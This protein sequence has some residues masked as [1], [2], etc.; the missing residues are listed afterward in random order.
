MVCPKRAAANK[1]NAQRSTGPRSVA[2]KVRSRVNALK[3]G[4]AVPASAMPELAPEIL[5]LAHT[6]AGPAADHPAVRQAATRVAEA[7][8]DV[9]RVRRV[10]IALVERLFEDLYDPHPVAPVPPMSPQPA[11]ITIATGDGIRASHDGSHQVR[12][13]AGWAQITRGGGRDAAAKRINHQWAEAEPAP[14]GPP[15]AWDQLYKLDR[16]ERRALSR[17]NKAIRALDAVLT[18]A[19]VR[20]PDFT[21]S[22]RLC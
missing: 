2:G 8:I 16:Y 3:H 11:E 19:G 15:S 14:R 9:M 18:A 13:P 7:A 5:H 12:G 10:R 4:L 20:A 21:G 6:L 17:R 22:T 1:A